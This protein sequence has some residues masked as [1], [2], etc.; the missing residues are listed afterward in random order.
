MT[1]SYKDSHERCKLGDME[2]I[3]AEDHLERYRFAATFVTGKTV[4]DI[5][6]GTGYGAAMLHEAGAT[7][8][9][10]AD[11]SE[12]AIAHAC[13][14]Y[15][16]EHIKFLVSGMAELNDGVRYDRIISFETIEH[17]DDYASALA[18]L[19]RL[20]KD[21]G[22]LVLSTP[23]RPVN[24]PQCATLADKPPNPYH[25]REFTVK[26]MVDALKEAG[27]SRV[28]LYGQKQ[29]RLF[30]NWLILSLY[31]VFAARLKLLKGHFRAEVLPSL[32]GMEPRWAVFVCRP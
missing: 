22:I 1:S 6:C 8:I 11:V 14:A 3:D 24:S 9:T 13:G 5:A 2:A 26:E 25:V 30:S 12:E 31:Y 4:L 10:G 18:N 17:I 16:A 23:N 21:D 15:P 20:L 32:D 7:S 19:R 27:F 29:R 28:A